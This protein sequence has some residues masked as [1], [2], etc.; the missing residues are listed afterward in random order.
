MEIILPGETLGV[1]IWIGIAIFVIALAVLI[2]NKHLTTLGKFLLCLG[3]FLCQL[4][5][6]CLR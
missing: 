5:V 2:A 6:V 1:L 4:L 3:A